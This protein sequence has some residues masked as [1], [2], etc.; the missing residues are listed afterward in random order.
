IFSTHS[1][2]VNQFR[3]GKRLLLFVCLVACAYAQVAEEVTEEVPL[4]TTETITT[5]E[6]IPTTIST[7][8]PITASTPVSILRQI[9]TVN[10]DGSYTYGFE[11][12]DGAFKIETRDSKGNVNGK[13]GYVDENGDL[14]IVEYGV[15]KNGNNSSSGFEAKSNLIPQQVKVKSFKVPVAPKSQPA[16]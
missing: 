14:K 2:S 4:E 16:V 7:A 1:S 5:T 12:A 9:N 3:M 6:T 8:A 13:Y 10:D 15:K 11:S